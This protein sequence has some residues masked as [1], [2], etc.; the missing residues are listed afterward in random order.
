MMVVVRQLFKGVRPRGHLSAMV[1][2]EF[3]I[4]DPPGSGFYALRSR[5]CIR[6]FIVFWGVLFFAFAVM[7]WVLSAVSV[8]GALQTTS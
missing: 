6:S 4:P 2:E 8:I 1:F 5:V 3:R 7:V